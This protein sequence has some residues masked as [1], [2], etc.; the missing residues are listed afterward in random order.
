MRAYY[1]CVR[2]VLLAGSV[3]YLAALLCLPTAGAAT[4]TNGSFEA[5]QIGS[6]FDSSNPANIPGWTHTGSTGDA[7]LWA[8]GYSDGGGNVTV[9]GDGNQ[10]V[11]LGGGFNVSGSAAWSTNITGLTAGASYL[12]NFDLANEGGDASRPESLTVSFS[13]GSATGSQVFTAPA[14]GLNYWKMWLPEQETFV[15]NAATATVS[16]SVTNQPFDMGLDAVSVASP[17]VPEPNTLFL[18][19]AGLLSGGWLGRKR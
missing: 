12:L 14:N 17:G 9:A 4:I 15:A 2:R 7:L 3:T 13:A 10:F 8:I 16:F 6:P 18:L 5:V 11:T 1:A 19:L